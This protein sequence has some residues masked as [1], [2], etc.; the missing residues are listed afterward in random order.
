[1]IA[2][3]MKTFAPKDYLAFL[4]YPKLS[5]SNSPL[6]QAGNNTNNVNNTIITNTTITI[7]FNRL[8]EQKEMQKLEFT[9]YNIPA[10][11][12]AL[13]KDVQAWRQCVNNVKS[14]QQHQRNKIL[15]LNIMSGK[16]I[17][18]K[19]L[20]EDMETDDINDDKNTKNE[21]ILAPLYRDYNK[22]LENTELLLNNNIGTLKRKID[23]ITVQRKTIAESTEREYK[24][25]AYKKTE[26]IQNLWRLDNACNN[27]EE[28]LQSNGINNIDEIIDQLIK[29]E[30]EDK[31]QYENSMEI[32]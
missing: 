8:K 10:P 3:E 4:P 23:S 26:A 11:P 16:D 15:N 27:L 18:I 22:S 32:I 13:D 14:Q 5:F 29:Q 30:E 19:E 31:Q 1:M 17:N 25:Y 24:R 9:R 28:Q 7:E 21:S 2:N 12:V 20:N 6:L